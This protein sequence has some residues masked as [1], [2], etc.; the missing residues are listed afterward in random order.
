MHWDSLAV[1]KFNTLFRNMVKSKFSL[2]HIKIM[3][4]DKDKNIIKPVI[5]SLLP[6]HIL[7]KFLKEVN[8][9]SKYFKKKPVPQQKKSYTQ[10][11]SSTNVSNITRDIL[12]IK[13]MFLDLK[14]CKIEQVQKII[15]NVE[16]PKS[17]INMI[18]KGLSHKQVIISM[19]IENAKY[20]M[21][22]SSMHMI[23]INRTL[24]GIKLNVMAD[25][26]CSDAK[27]I[28]ISTNNITCLFNLQEI[29]KYVKST[30]CAVAD[31][32]KTPRLPQLKSYLKIV[33]IP[34]VSEFT[35]LRIILDDVEK[36]H[37]ANYIFNDIVLALKPRFIKVLPKLDMSIV[38]INI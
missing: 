23:N 7:A 38:W 5:I 22:E 32:I 37:K 10:A 18:M 33:G 29:K 1:D 25:F 15:S 8:E 2:Q 34:F 19:S 12:K 26:A 30:L 31:Q 35:N 20:F 24:K 6:P 13:E 28:I 36:I 14:D 11:S 27:D 4:N 17:K 21:R 3:T 16:K 9:I